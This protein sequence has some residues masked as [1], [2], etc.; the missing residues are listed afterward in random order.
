[1]KKKDF[2]KCL[3]SLIFVFTIMACENPEPYGDMTI[4]VTSFPDDNFVE[5][6]QVTLYSTLEDFNTETN[7]LR[8]TQLTDKDGKVK[9]FNLRRNTYYI[10]LVK[11]SLNNWES[12]KIKRDIIITDNG[13]VNEFSYTIGMT[14]AGILSSPKGKIWKITRVLKDGEDI[15]DTFEACKLD[16][17][18]VFFKGGKYILDQ[19]IA[20]CNASHP[21]QSIGTW[22]F[23]EDDTKI[24]LS[25]NNSNHE[26]NLESIGVD[27]FIVLSK[28]LINE[29]S[30]NLMITFELVSP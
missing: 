8:E 28:T 2:I 29:D 10:N 1:M 27:Q 5:G 22:A 4:S 16:D 14:R 23:S 21:Q 19:G 18:Y 17:Q 24:Q 12:S 15:T 26:L 25:V 20:K 9:F 3:S 11:G 30:A 6:V 7:S 13:F